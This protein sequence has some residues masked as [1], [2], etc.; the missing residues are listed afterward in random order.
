MLTVGFDFGTHQTKVCYETVEEGTA[1]HEV[2][3]FRR[4]S[5]KTSLTLPSI[6]QL[7]TNG[8]LLYGHDALDKAADG[9]TITYFKQIMFSWTASEDERAKAEQWSILYLAFVILELDWYFQ[10]SRYV[11]HMGMP[12]DA[13]PHHYDY[14]KRQAIKVMASA[15]LLARMLFR[16]DKK[17][18]LGTSYERLMACVAKC[19]AAVPRDVHEARKRFPIFVFPE[20]YVALLPLIKDR[21]L[22]AVGPNL[23]VDIG[24]GTVDISFFTAHEGSV[25][26]LYYYYSIPCGLN[27][28]TGQ[29]VDASHN[30]LVGQGQITPQ[31]VEMFRR[32][33]VRAVDAIVSNLRRLYVYMGRANV[34]PFTNLCGQILDG[35]PICYSGGGS[36]FNELRVPMEHVPD[37][38]G[39]SYNFSNVATVSELINHSSLYVDEKIFHVLATAYALSHHDLIDPTRRPEPD[40]IRLAP[41]EYLFRGVHNPLTDEQR[42]QLERNGHYMGDFRTSSGELI[43]PEGEDRSLISTDSG[44]NDNH[45]Y[46]TRPQT[47]EDVQRELYGDW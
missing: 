23:F 43:L 7:C 19:M 47:L 44:G 40:S 4:P 41:V 26:W 35:R 21:R 34:M 14:C 10:H 17:A 29:D 25:P 30:V 45:D 46:M 33:L 22:P 32:E 16:G 13:D 38:S 9:I 15:I 42:E 6:I 18:Y 20:A 1:I 31:G 8:R 5:G 12:T 3:R 28:I 36:I 39:F 2:F 27:V 24:G 37:G 11:L